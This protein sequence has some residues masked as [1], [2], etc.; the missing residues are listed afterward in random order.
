LS[1]ESWTNAERYSPRHAASDRACA[2]P[3]SRL[4]CNSAP[5]ELQWGTYYDAADEAGRS[6]LWG[7]MHIPPD[8]FDG[9]KIGDR[10]GE[11]ALARVKEIF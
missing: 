6:R 3:V 5:I 10:I 8:D 2:Q 9:R 4:D 7:G 1:S 11:S